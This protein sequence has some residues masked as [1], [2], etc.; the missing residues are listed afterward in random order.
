[1]IDSPLPAG[2]LRAHAGRRSGTRRRRAVVLTHQ[3]ADRLDGERVA[4][5]YRHVN[6]QNL[7]VEQ[8]A[9]GVAEDAGL[10][11]LLVPA[12]GPAKRRARGGRR[13]HAV[14]L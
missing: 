8:F 11:E 2:L 14:S 4:G 1:M 3:G 5:R 12:P 13:D 7:A 6:L 9:V 10:G